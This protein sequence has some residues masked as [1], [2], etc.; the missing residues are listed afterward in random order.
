MARGTDHIA[1]LVQHLH[2]QEMSRRAFLRTVGLGG[3]MAVAGAG[4]AQPASAQTVKCGGQLRL[5]WIETVDTLDPHFTSSL[6]AIKIH[7]NIYNGILKVEYDGKRVSFAPD[8]IEKWDMPNPT[9]HV[10]K[11]RPGV[12]FHDG[13]DC[14]AEAIKW[15]QER[16]KDP[17]VKSSHAWKLAYLDKVTVLDKHTVRITFTP[18]QP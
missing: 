10:L 3:A 15:N 4:T 2:A 7:D 9:T 11:V 6:G 14:D 8:V 18:R 13:T 5:G 17:N 1:V 12:K 16:V